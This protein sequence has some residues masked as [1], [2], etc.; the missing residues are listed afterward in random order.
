V[1]EILHQAEQFEKE[2]D[3]LGAVGLY[4][5]ALKLLP[6]DDFSRRSET[7]ERLGYAFYRAAFQAESHDEFRQ[8]LRHAIASCEE[9]KNL[10]GKSEE[11]TKTARISRCSAMIAYVNYWLA[12]EASERTRQLDEC[13]RMEREALKVCEETGNQLGLG[14]ACVELTEY[15]DDRLDLELNMQ[16]REKILDEALRLGEKAI[17]V[18]SKAGDERELARAYCITGIQ[19]YNA[20]LSLQLETKRR[21]FEQ[22]AFEYAKEAIRISERIGDEVF[23]SRSTVWLGFAELDMGGGFEKASQLFEDAL[24]HSTQVKDH[25]VL[26]ELFD[27][28]AYSATWSMSFEENLEKFREKS[29]KSEEYASKAICNSNLVDYGRGIPHSYSNGYVS[30]FAELARREID[31]ETRYELLK[32]AVVLGK[33][34]LEQAKRTGSTHAISHVSMFLAQALYSLS[35]M[36]AEVEKRQLL[37]EAMAL[38]ETAV[39]YTEQLRPHFPMAQSWP[40]LALAFTLFELSKLEEGREKKK[41]L[42]EKSVS[43]ME[44]RVTLV[45]KHLASFPS[46]REI[47]AEL[48][49]AQAE[50][51]SVLNQLYQVTGE[52]EVL[53]K[54]IETYQSAIQTNKKAGLIS[55]V[56]EAYWQT[57]VAYDRLGEYLESSRDFEF[58]S[59]QYELSAQ[60]IPQ[61]NSF[62]MDYATYMQAWSQIEKARHNHEAQEYGL[63]KEH[64][65]KAAELHKSLKRWSYL[66]PN[67]SAWARVEG[68]EELSRKEQNEEAI[69]AFEQAAALFGESKKCLQTQFSKIEDTDE[70]QMATSM[71]KA[72]DLRHEYCDARVALEEARILDKKGDHFASSRKYGSAAKTFERIVQTLESEQERKEFRYITNLSRAWEKM[73]LGDAKASPESYL[74]A[75]TLF[76][77]ASKESSTE[78]AGFLA[79]GHSRFCRA[80]EA[81][82]RFADTRDATMHATATKYLESASNYYVSAGF[83]K[84]S[85][86]AKATGLL[87]EAYA[88]MDNAKRESDAEKKAK[89]YVMAEK[90]LQTSA[91]SFMKAEH[92]EKKERVLRMLEKVQEERE[93]AVSLTEVLHASSI[94]SST[95]VFTTPTPTHEE[96]VGSER[97][98]QADIQA[99]MIARQ[100]ELRVG[101]PLD[102]EIELVNAGKAPALLIKVNEVIPE[103]FDL[104]EKP[105]TYR[106]EDSYI[107]MKGKRLGPLKTEEL[108]LVL[109]PKIQG[110][111]ALKPTILY[112]DENGKYKSHKPEPVTITVKELGIKGWLK[113]ER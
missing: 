46:R 55:R 3:W 23:R 24:H 56:A 57:A 48:G 37:E 105:E 104:T 84:A 14:R 69:K 85:E 110:I 13:W 103:G 5:K 100:K 77:Q 68:A 86:Y 9:T 95:A 2:Y 71:T 25:R 19:C 22:K 80:L 47:I 6:E 106:V 35:T 36:E 45:Q 65:E 88:Q 74:E 34:G 18:F 16:M 1:E 40:Y 70:K 98:E 87:F 96:A 108:R 101:E 39:Y 51:G 111:F 64:F 59:E 30:N 60:N 49:R 58:A 17:Q 12:A 92:P 27:G 102:L 81:G 89:L 75:S 97:F 53:R 78:I 10:C 76:E 67:Y 109:K 31:L 44:T 83:Q 93:L 26:S 15:L 112:L 63:A 11:P 8:R 113:G 32:K 90:V 20:A 43:R 72:S 94:V 62:Y 52:K 4:E 50:L 41:E 73:M 54:L 91:G 21:E 61:L 7:F 42:L 107:D 38:G 82:T 66:E 79:L 28:L 33:Q 99:N 29:G